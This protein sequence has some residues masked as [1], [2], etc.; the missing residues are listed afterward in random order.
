MQGQP[1]K[2][3]FNDDKAQHLSPAAICSPTRA[4]TSTSRE[5]AFQIICIIDREVWPGMCVCVCLSCEEG[6]SSGGSTVEQQD[7][8][9]YVRRALAM[10]GAYV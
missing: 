1:L 9:R 10:G 6:I 7:L 4:L 5:S 3:T 8:M 2:P